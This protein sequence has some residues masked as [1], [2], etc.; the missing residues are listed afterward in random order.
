VQAVLLIVAAVVVVAAIA[1]FLAY[2]RLVRLRNH[3]DES[4]HNVDTELQRRYDLVP[5]LV[6]TVRG[7][8]AHE[9]AVFE[10]VTTRRAEAMSGPR[11]PDA[12]APLEQAL[13]QGV[14]QVMAVAEHYPDLRASEQFLGLQRELVDT[15][16]RIQVARRI[17]NA[18]VRA[19]NNMVQGF[20]SLL[21]AGAM[22]YEALP[23]FEIDRSV[24]EAGPPPVDVSGPAA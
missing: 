24:R 23:F 8:A 15:E 20:P 22:H 9:R 7:Y 21:V 19:Y 13:G 5:N 11:A 4:W 17:Y 3:I 16:D 6:E 14:A 10:S 12:Q 1:L 2:N 18:N